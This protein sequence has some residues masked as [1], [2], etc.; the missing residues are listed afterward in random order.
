MSLDSVNQKQSERLWN[1]LSCD[2]SNRPEHIPVCL[3]VCEC[4]FTGGFFSSSS[5]KKTSH[6]IRMCPLASQPIRGLI[7]PARGRNVRR[8]PKM[9]I[10]R[11]EFPVGSWGET[12]QH[13]FKSSSSHS[14]QPI[15]GLQLLFNPW[16]TAFFRR[17]W[18][19]KIH[20]TLSACCNSSGLRQN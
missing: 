20:N 6:P 13:H 1:H 10:N 12:F 3:C 17:H 5:I 15:T 7:D 18:G 14:F 4:V 2:G 16:Q 9:K 11:K 19:K 8:P